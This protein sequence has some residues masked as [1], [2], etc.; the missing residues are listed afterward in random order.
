M[1]VVESY[2][3]L[4][5]REHLAPASFRLL[6][7]KQKKNRAQRETLREDRK[8]MFVNLFSRNIQR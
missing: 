4:L 7:Y 8:L 6:P 3:L 2:E 1:S 5:E